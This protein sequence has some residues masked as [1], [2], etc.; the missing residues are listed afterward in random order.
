MKEINEDIIKF[1]IK[2]SELLLNMR[3][4]NPNIDE[5]KILNGLRNAINQELEILTIRYRYED[6]I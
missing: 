4:L 1:Q 6:L 5:A 3:G 2:V